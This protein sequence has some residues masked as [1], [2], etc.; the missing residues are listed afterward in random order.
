MLETIGNQRPIHIISRSPNQCPIYKTSNE[1]KPIKKYKGSVVIFDDM[2]G[3]RQ[4]SH[5]N[6]FFTR[7]T[8]DGLSVFFVSQIYFGL[9]RQRIN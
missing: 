5:I 8:H 7:G 4:S 9:Q 2:L 3:A 1:I 6:E